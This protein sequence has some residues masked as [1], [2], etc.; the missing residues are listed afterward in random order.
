MKKVS[1]HAVR[2]YDTDSAQILFFGNQFRF[3]N[4]AFEDLLAEMEIN[5]FTLF[6]QNE[7]GFVVVHAESDYLAPSRV[8][9]HL[10][11]STW[12]SH[13][14]TSSFEVSYELFNLNSKKPIGKS[15]SVH[16]TIQPKTGKKIPIPSLFREKL[17]T[18][19]I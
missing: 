17:Q 7:F 19:L 6:T 4:D 3:I 16:V 5:F 14:G 10:E 2:M 13:I 15:K 8:G 9:D 12:I 11:I 1:R 18:Y